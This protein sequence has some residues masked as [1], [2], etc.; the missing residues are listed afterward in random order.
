ME[1]FI[2]DDVEHSIPAE[3]SQPERIPIIR[4]GT[5]GSVKKVKTETDAK[6]PLLVRKSFYKRLLRL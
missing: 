6:T 2:A 1:F 5:A 3:P 4:R